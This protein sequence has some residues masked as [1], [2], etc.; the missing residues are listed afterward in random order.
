MADVDDYLNMDLTSSPPR[1]NSPPRTSSPLGSRPTSPTPATLDLQEQPINITS[2]RKRPAEDSSAFVDTVVRSYKLPKTEADDL[3]AFARYTPMQQRIV[4]AGSLL[5]LHS[6]V[7]K[8]DPPDAVF[9]IPTRLAKKCDIVVFRTLLDP[10]L[11]AY[12]NDDIP[13]KKALAAL[14]AN[15]AW[16]F[17]KEMKNCE[18]KYHAIASKLRKKFN[19]GRHDMKGLLVPSTGQADPEDPTKRV[20]AINIVDLCDSLIELNESAV[21]A[22]TVELCG[23]VAFL[24]LVASHPPS[25]GTNYW[26]IV[27]KKLADACKKHKSA[28]ALSKFFGKIL[29]DDMKKYGEINISTAVRDR[30]SAGLES[31]EHTD[32]EDND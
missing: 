16:G 19:D 5:S 1:S 10:N 24:R 14:E 7:A 22:T 3:S 15:P 9:V 28:R 29:E 12:V 2:A 13:V 23:R 4:L 30:Q 8:I 6:K 18:N 20:Q 21:K 27:D 26:K 25:A 17:T 11:S 32:E 31:H